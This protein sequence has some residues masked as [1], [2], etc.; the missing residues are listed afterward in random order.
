M[1]A[2]DS[3][4]REAWQ[5]P[6]EKLDE[7]RWLIPKSFSAGMRVPG[8]IYADEDLLRHIRTDKT[9]LQVANV[10]HLPGIQKFSL[11]MPDIHW[12]YGFC[13]GGVAGM[14]VDGGIVSPGGVGYDINC[15]VRLVRTNLTLPD[16]KDRMRDLVNALYDNVPSGVG[17]K[18]KVR[19]SGREVE[20]VLVNGAKWAVKNGFGWQEDITYTEAQGCLPGADPAKASPRAIER[21]KPQLG[22]LGAGNHFLEIQ[23]VEEVFHDEAAKVMGLE[24][25]QIVVMIHT[26]SR[27]LGYQICD[28][29]IKV[30]GSAMDRHGIKIPDRQLA[31]APINSKEGEDYLSAMAAAANYAWTN[32]QMILHWVRESFERVMGKSAEKLDMHLIYD[33]AHNIAKIEKHEVDG[34]RKTLCVHRKGATRAFPPNHPEIPD[35]YKGIGQPVLIPGDMGTASYVL[36]GTDLA[37]K[38]TFG[39]TCHG[40]GRVMSRHAAIRAT[41]GRSIQREM[42]A[43]GIEVRAHSNRVL[44]EEVSEAYKDVDKVVDVCHRV[45]ISTKV[46]RMRPLGVV[47]G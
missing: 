28:D 21:G 25:G 12:G 9:P 39:S 7:C 27:G 18:G 22:S 6:L 13:I 10:A 11:A 41:K 2:K 16:I 34:T 35:K 19:I 3:N 1:A 33:V 24:Q 38:E 30:L 47:K 20:D 43:K 44:S 5:G 32:R 29:Y 26:G 4:L 8:L 31:C 23:R 36:V 15:G 37:M 42:E 17:S 45:G 14:D 46:A 40:A